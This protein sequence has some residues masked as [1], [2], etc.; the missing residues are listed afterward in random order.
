MTIQTIF[1]YSLLALLSLGSC[2]LF[3]SEEEKAPYYVVKTDESKDINKLGKLINLD[4]FRPK[5]IEFQH[6]Y[7]ETINGNGS[8]E[9]KDDYL[10]VVLYFDPATFKK[11]LQMS[12]NADYPKPNYPRSLFEFPWLSSELD[13]ELENSDP[14][15]HGHPDLFFESEGGKIWFLD[16]KVLLY[17]EIK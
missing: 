16:Q 5:K 17:R 13:K 6:I 15:Y 8:E 2:E 14:A 4:K 12:G 7:I 9:P 10:Q 3:G 11:M 1:T